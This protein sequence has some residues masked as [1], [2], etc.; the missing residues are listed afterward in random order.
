MQSPQHLMSNS[1][2][3]MK[4]QS[5]K[6]WPEPI[7]RRNSSAWVSSKTDNGQGN[8]KCPGVSKND[9]VLNSRPHMYCLFGENNVVWLECYYS[10]MFLI[11]NFIS[12]KI[13]TTLRYYLTP[14]RIIIKKPTNK[15]WRGCGEREHSY[16]AGGN[17]N[18]CSHYRGSSYF[19][20][21]TIKSG[22]QQGLPQR[23]NR[24]LKIELPYDSA[25]PLPGIHPEKDII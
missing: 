21:S 23:L 2:K 14:V 11:K 10:L 17:V 9:P 4:V 1:V 25:I 18:L 3:A 16:T 19:S 8:L 13:E 5:L 22:H 7:T 24:K 20:N 12:M 6:E 15:C